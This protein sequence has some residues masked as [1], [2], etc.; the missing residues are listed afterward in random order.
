MFDANGH[1]QLLVPGLE[2][3]MPAALIL[4]DGSKHEFDLRFS[5]LTQV[6]RVA[7]SW[8]AP[9]LFAL[10]ALE[11][12]AEPGS[13]GH[14]NPAN[15]GSYDEVRRS[16]GG[17]LMAYAPVG[18]V[19]HSVQFYTHVTKHTGIAG[20]VKLTLDYTSRNLGDPATCGDAPLAR[21]E[22]LLLRSEK[23]QLARPVRGSHESIGCAVAG[24]GRGRLGDQVGNVVIR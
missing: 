24:D 10:N 6:T 9:V 7:I 16:G 18:G 13:A 22:F 8:E 11:F 3:L 15:P 4:A 5:G 12:D 21:P 23:G 1:G 2:P 14:L 17:F 20:V 19:G